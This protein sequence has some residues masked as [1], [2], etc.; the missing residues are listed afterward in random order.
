LGIQLE[1]GHALAVVNGRLR[2]VAF[3][4]MEDYEF[5]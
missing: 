4:V 3:F 1:F 2:K 5:F